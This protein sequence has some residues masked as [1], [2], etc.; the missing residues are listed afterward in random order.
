MIALLAYPMFESL[1]T[2]FTTGN[3]SGRND[4][5][6]FKN[7]IRLFRQPEFFISLW[8]SLRF[9]LSS[10][11]L[12]MLLGLI[13]ALVLNSIRVIKNIFRSIGLIPMMLTPVIVALTWRLFWDTDFG[14]VNS[15]LV[16]L[17]GQKIGWL[18]D[19]NTAYWAV[20]ITDVWQN[21]PYVMMMCLAG[22]QSIPVENL[23]AATIDGANA[24]QKLIRIILPL[25]KPMIILSLIVR[26]LFAFR[27]FEP[28]YILTNGGPNNATLQ[29]SIFVFRL[30]FR[31]FQTGMAAA[32][33]WIMLIICMFI[34]LFYI[35]V[36][37][38]GDGK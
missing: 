26:T 29:M 12:Q 28:V 13:T 34:T 31:Y 11:A 38:L 7:F 6:G 8:N 3:I 17:G 19:M 9:T 21:A 25:L 5:V 22:L 15:I 23:E 30:G 33:S 18:A 35:K 4:F 10:V 14:V 36:L 20:V 2:S 16:A 32:L 1:K 37:G 24:W 27:V